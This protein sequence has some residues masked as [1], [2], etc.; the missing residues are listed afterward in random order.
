MTVLFHD[1]HEELEGK[2][3]ENTFDYID[4]VEILYADDTL[5]IGDN[6]RVLNLLVAAIEKHSSRYGMK[7]NKDKC[8]YI[9]MNTKAKIKFGDKKEMKN[10]EEAT[11]LGSAMSRKHLTR[12]EIEARISS[13][14]GTV[15]KLRLFYKK[16]KCS[17]AWKLQVYNAVI[18]S[19][20]LYGIESLE[21]TESLKTRLNAFQMKGLRHILKIDHSFWSH[22][23]N[24][25][26]IGKANVVADTK[27]NI[28]SNWQQILQ[29]RNNK[30]RQIKLV[31][32]VIEDRQTKLLGHILRSND[33]DPMKQVCFNN[34]GYQH[35]YEKRRVGRPRVNWVRQTMKRTFNKMYEDEVYMEDDEEILFKLL[36][37]AENRDF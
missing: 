22:V 15:K 12:K 35:L 14:L 3:E 34:E 2:L 30:E 33:G 29:N 7:L 11:Y 37:C 27:E 24:N 23:T 36:L 31:S 17:E 5:L 16:T 4:F 13:A 26:I 10:A 9:N 28:T 8:L 1:I 21:F 6:T 19:R 20:L 25:E 32:E 18:I